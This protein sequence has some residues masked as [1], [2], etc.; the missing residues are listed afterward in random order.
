[1]SRGEQLTWSIMATALSLAAIAGLLALFWP[2]LVKL[3]S[4]G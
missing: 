4:G 1:M 3:F 2:S